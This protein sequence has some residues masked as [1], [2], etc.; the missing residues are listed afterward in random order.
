[1]YGRGQTIAPGAHSQ[2]GKSRGTG[3]RWQVPWAAVER[4]TAGISWR[5][6][7]GNG[8]QS[9][10]GALIV[11]PFSAT[12]PCVPYLTK[13]WSFPLLFIQIYVAPVAWIHVNMDLLLD[14]GMDVIFTYWWVWSSLPTVRVW[15]WYL[16]IDEYDHLYLLYGYGYDL[17]LSYTALRQCLSASACLVICCTSGVLCCLIGVLPVWHLMCILW[18]EIITVAVCFRLK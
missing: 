6:F 18:C 2:P 10:S 8:V 3:G 12:L 11:F 4:A 1:L 7:G 17:Y 9:A 5:R 15:I 14:R 16:P 13:V